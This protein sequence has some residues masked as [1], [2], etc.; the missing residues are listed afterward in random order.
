M[1]DS[2][3]SRPECAL[4]YDSRLEETQLEP[5]RDAAI[6]MI[7]WADRETIAENTR[8]MVCLSDE[9]IR[10]LVSLAVQR[11]WQLAVLPH[12]DATEAMRALA[13]KGSA[14]GV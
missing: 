8:V 10:D 2:E 4:L 14:S 7:A 6:K 1:E 5:Y 12:P 13:V 11:Q 3:I 9:A